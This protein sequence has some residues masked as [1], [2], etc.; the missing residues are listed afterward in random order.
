MSNYHTRLFGRK[1]K[2]CL[3]Q[4]LSLSTHLQCEGLP[5]RANVFVHGCIRI[6]QTLAAAL[7]TSFKAGDPSVGNMPADTLRPETLDECRGLA[8]HLG[9]PNLA[10]DAEPCR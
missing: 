6:G 8:V 2:L 9:G 5:Y 10:Q 1:A 4:A 7:L 3:R